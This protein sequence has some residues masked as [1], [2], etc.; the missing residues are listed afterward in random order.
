MGMSLV[1]MLAGTGCLSKAK[2]KKAIDDAASARKEADEHKARAAE[3]QAEVDRLTAA[4][5]QAEEKGQSD[6]TRA[7]LEELRKQK[8]AVEERLRLFEDFVKK[9]QKMIDAGKLEIAVRRGRIVLVLSTDV[10][11]DTGKTE[12]KDDGKAALSEIAR[13]LK[14]VRG[15]QF[16]VAGHTDNAPIRTKQFPSN[17]ELSAGRA[18]EVTHLLIRRGVRPNQLSAAGYGS[19]DPVASNAGAGGRAKNRRIEITLQPDIQ[20]LIKLPIPEKKT[21]P[22]TAP[23]P[24]PKTDE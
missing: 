11:F 3:L 13:T 7:E 17:W 14:D 23:E 9:F 12:I 21:E 1:V 18:L 4:L 24:S 22:D 5:R 6:D 2:Y 10:L 16:Q 20:D 8:A 19:H 15:R